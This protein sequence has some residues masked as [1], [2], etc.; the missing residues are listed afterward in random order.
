MRLWC[1]AAFLALQA[2]S[3]PRLCDVTPVPP[4]A[5]LP[6]TAPAGLVQGVVV[7]LPDS[8]PLPYV[9]LH[10]DSTDAWAITDAQGRFALAAVRPGTF[11]LIV[12]TV[13]YGPARL[14]LEMLPGRG[15][16]VRIPLVPRCFQVEAVAN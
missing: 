7:A 6:D 3:H 5:M 9:R 12:R 1:I 14:P 15:V 13:N 11:S 10:V 2:C 4:F 8:V 16:A